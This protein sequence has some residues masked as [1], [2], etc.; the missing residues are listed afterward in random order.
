MAL[1]VR[2][3]AGAA[4]SNSYQTVAAVTALLE[5]V[6]NASAWDTAEQNIL[7]VYA[8]TMLEVLAYKGVKATLAQALQ[9][10][11]VGVLNVD[12]GDDQ[13]GVGYKTTTG[14]GVYYDFTTVPVRMLRA[15]AQL[16]LALA[17]A[18]TA[19]IWGVDASLNVSGKSVGPLRTDFVPRRERRVGLRIHPAV[20]REV[21]P[22]TLA[23]E[24]Q[25]VERA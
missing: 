3:I 10:P 13:T 23:S 19:E 11:R 25:T 6:P 7:A 4:D 20:W 5:A 21:F 2:A 15:H 8:T 9:W 14:W 18:G 24:P 12:Y 1:V 16:C 22:L 17:R